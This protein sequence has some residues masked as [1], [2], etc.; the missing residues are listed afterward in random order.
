MWPIKEKENRLLLILRRYCSLININP[1]SKSWIDLRTDRSLEAI[2]PGAI[3][4]D[5]KKNTVENYHEV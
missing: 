4:L 5:N 3:L 2:R 1:S